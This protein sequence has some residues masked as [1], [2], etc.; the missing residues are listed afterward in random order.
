MLIFYLTGECSSDR[1]IENFKGGKGI[2]SNGHFSLLLEEMLEKASSS[3]DEEECFIPQ[4]EIQAFKAKMPFVD[5]KRSQ[6]RQILKNRFAQLCIK[7]Q[8]SKA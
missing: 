4:E 2:K 8:T 3:A 7:S 5:E 1:S 6:L